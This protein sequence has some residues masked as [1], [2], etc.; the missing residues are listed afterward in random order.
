MTRY[1]AAALVSLALL[2]T[3]AQAKDGF[4]A[5]RCG[6]DVAKA[7]IGKRMSD[8]PVAAIEKRHAELGLTDLGGDEI[9]DR[10]NATSWQICGSEYLL[11]SDARGT[12]RDVV[13]FP[14]HSRRFPQ[15]AA[16]TCRAGGHDLP[17]LTVAI[18]D[19]PAAAGAGHYDPQDK[20]PLP[21]KAAWRIDETAA[22]FVTLATNGL[23]CPRGGIVTVDGG[24]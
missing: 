21:A 3:A 16:G 14:A 2:C 9:S 4:E 20:M 17:G 12:V 10:L 13:L 22:K 18:L 6:G 19:N 11:L 24:P 8:E 15:F 5:V 23:T 1:F 7:L